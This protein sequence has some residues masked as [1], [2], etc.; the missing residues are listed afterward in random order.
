MKSERLC[1][2]RDV[3]LTYTIYE[4]YLWVNNINE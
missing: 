2:Y 1:N 3:L 4:I